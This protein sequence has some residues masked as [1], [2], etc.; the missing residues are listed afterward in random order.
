MNMENLLQVSC[1]DIFRIETGLCVR[2]ET[3]FRRGAA[4]Q[5]ALQR[6]NTAVANIWS[7]ADQGHQRGN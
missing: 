5:I 2:T 3:V 6:L 7:V 1:Q 4:T